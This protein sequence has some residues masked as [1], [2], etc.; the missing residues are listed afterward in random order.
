MGCRVE[1]GRLLCVFVGQEN[2]CFC[3]CYGLS[4][5]VP[6]I[7]VVKPNPQYDHNWRWDLWEVIGS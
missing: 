7:Q 2:F 4:E 6:C 3:N 5:C 1:V